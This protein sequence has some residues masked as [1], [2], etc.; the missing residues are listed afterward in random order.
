MARE[1]LDPGD[2]GSRDFYM[3]TTPTASS[4]ILDGG[5]G[6]NSYTC[7]CRIATDGGATEPVSISAADGV[8]DGTYHPIYP[9]SWLRVTRELT[10]SDTATNDILNGYF[11]TNGSDWVWMGGLDYATN[12]TAGPMPAQ[13]YIGICTVAHEGSGAND[14]L[15]ATVTIANFGPYVV[16]PE[17][18]GITAVYAAATKT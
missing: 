10:I 5:T 6:E 16:A 4:K 11:S 7:Q 14:T 2:G 1:T 9:T 8:A 3:C 15:E 18:P 13:I 12:G 17:G